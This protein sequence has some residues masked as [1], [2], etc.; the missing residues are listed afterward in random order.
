M[1]GDVETET[2]NMFIQSYASAFS[3]EIMNCANQVKTS[4]EIDVTCNL[5]KSGTVVDD[6]LRCMQSAQ[7]S[8]T[9]YYNAVRQSWSKSPSRA[10]IALSIDQDMQ[11]INMRLLNC[12]LD[13]CLTCKA[14]NL[15]Q[16]ID[17]SDLTTCGSINDINVTLQNNV[18]ASLSQQLNSTRDILGGL[19]G[20]FGGGTSLNVAT[21]I[22]NKVFT[23]IKDLEWTNMLSNIK[24]EQGIIINADDGVVVPAVTQSS[25][26]AQVSTLLA[27]MNI[28][29]T[30]F[31]NIDLQVL[32]DLV[33][34]QNTIGELGELVPK[35]TQSFSDLVT[36]AIKAWARFMIILACGVS[37]VSVLFMIYQAIKRAIKANAGK[38]D[39]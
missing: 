25:V 11:D 20:V 3:Q 35:L 39:Q 1:G 4:Q 23:S 19:A 29:D 24:Q 21:N 38:R 6:C 36:G 7:D 32:Q 27:N 5:G 14:T 9:Q 15:N 37:I 22:S 28:S 18:S 8:K 26:I 30:I 13:H 34:S 10:T 16:M 2:T 33:N 12:G 31:N 17:V